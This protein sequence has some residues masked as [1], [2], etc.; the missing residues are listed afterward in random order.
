[1]VLLQGGIH[2]GEIDGKDAGLWLLRELLEGRAAPGALGRLTLVLVPVLNA[3]GHERFAPNQRPNQRGPEA[4]GWRVTA[5]NLNLNRD[6]LKAEATEL[7]ALLRLLGRWD[8]I[9]YA[10]LHVTDGAQFQH[11]VSVNVAP[12]AGG[13]AALVALGQALSSE[14]LRALGARGHLPLD[15]YPSF[16][17]ADDPRSG[18]AAGVAPPRFSHAYWAARNRVGVL[19]ETH[20]WKPYGQR[21]KATFDAC[22]AMLAHVAAHGAELQA[23]AAA[24][25][26]EDAHR[27]GQPLALEWEPTG[28]S[29][30]IDF[31]GY[32]YTVEASVVS[33]KPWVRY[34]ESRPEVW[35][36]PYFEALRPAGTV[37]V[38]EAGWL[39]PPPH[40]GWV[41]AKLALH[42][43][44]FRSLPRAV[45]AARVR[46][47]RATPA[48]QAASFEGRQPVALTGAWADDVQELPAGTLFVPAA[49]ARLRLAM[50]LLEPTLPDSLAAWGFFNA[51]LEQK[52][53][54]E[55]YL[56]E[57]FAR[58]QL[59][60]PAVRAAFEARLRDQ[61]FAASPEARL[62]FFAVRHPSADARQ[63]LLPV[64]QAVAVP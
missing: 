10:D 17:T 29:R 59:E 40:A 63:G 50:H 1:V 44:A 47:F 35:R 58:E 11:D 55:D 61:A 26:L 48:F 54:L 15:F 28:V 21:V 25:D 56:A 7:Q 16:R 4:M 18:F 27:A 23:A 57:A 36:V 34:D 3:D 32:A 5:A 30:P 2:A 45:P 42:G 20:S 62:R 8:P 53:Y 49:Q 37:R 31:Q 38:P 24:A 19:V 13:A 9:L 41:G 33:G 39:V 12:L 43:V 64:Y 46:T 14:L 6:Y 60:D 22:E 52:E 51:H